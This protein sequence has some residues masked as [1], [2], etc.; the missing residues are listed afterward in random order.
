LKALK[1]KGVGDSDVFSIVQSVRAAVR[2]SGRV[3]GRDIDTITADEVNGRSAIFN[4]TSQKQSSLTFFIYHVSLPTELSKI[5]SI[6]IKEID[7]SSFDYEAIVKTN[8]SACLWSHPG[9]RI[10][11]AT[12]H[13]FLKGFQH[14]SVEVFRFETQHAELMFERVLTMLAFIK[15]GNFNGNTIFLDSDAFPVK[16]LRALFDYPFDVAVTHR[17]IPTVMPINE[18]VIFAS[19]ARKDMVASCFEHYL[20]T[21]LAIERSPTISKIY[22]NLRRWR[23]GQLAINGMAGGEMVYKTGIRRQADG[24][25]I[26][27]LPCARFNQT[28]DTF[29]ANDFSFLSNAAIIHFKGGRKNW[30]SSFVSSLTQLGV[31]LVH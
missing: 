9:C 15:S 11:L 18:G 28:R 20:G 24:A 14:P 4:S 19:V 26:G 10:V 25:N 6:D 12:D 17:N 7:H 3:R 13:N 29:A 5:S 23:G 22:Q 21:Y 1:A 27:L 31:S 8:I 16:D 30:A 2:E